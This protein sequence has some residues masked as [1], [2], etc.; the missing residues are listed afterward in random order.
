MSHGGPGQHRM[1]SVTVWERD[2]DSLTRLE[3]CKT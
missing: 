3:Q 1:I 2:P